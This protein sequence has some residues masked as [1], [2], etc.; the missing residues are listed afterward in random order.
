MNLELFAALLMRWAHILAAIV[1][2]GGSIFFRFVFL[3]AAGACLTGDQSAR[4]R[5]TFMVRWKRIVHTCIALFLI[6]GLYN[7]LVIQR[8]QHEGQA[9]YHALFGVKFLL[10][11]AV[12]YLALALTAS[13]A[14][15]SSLRR[16]AAYWL[17]MLVALAV[18]VVLI[19]GYMRTAF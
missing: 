16:R 4:L 3:P 18:I 11:L 13:G 19:S 7:Y 1:A 14:F 6:S 9:L 5:Q 8:P 15:G 2:L 12:F 10:A 17:A